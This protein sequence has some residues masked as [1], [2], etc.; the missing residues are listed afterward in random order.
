MK[1]LTVWRAVSAQVASAGRQWQDGRHGKRKLVA[2]CTVGK[3]GTR[4]TGEWPT[5]VAAGWHR[6]RLRQVQVRR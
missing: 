3:R 1:V 2:R 5:D 4:G 6:R